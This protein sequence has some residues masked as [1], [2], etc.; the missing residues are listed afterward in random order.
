VQK[1]IN[2]KSYI[3]RLR[4]VVVQRYHLCK[5]LHSPAVVVNLGNQGTKFS[6]FRCP[7]FRRRNFR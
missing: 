5:C 1:R 3:V 6:A 2:A 7:Q 4:K